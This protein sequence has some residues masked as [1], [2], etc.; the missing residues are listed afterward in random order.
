MILLFKKVGYILF[1]SCLLFFISLNT[2]IY[3]NAKNNATPKAQA[4]TMIILGAKIIDTPAKP[5]KTLTER[6][7]AAIPYLKA[8]LNTKVIVCGG[9]GL[10]ESA[11]EASVM[12]QYLVNHGIEGNRIFEEDQSVRTAQQFILPKK[13]MTLGHTVVVTSD[14]HLLRAMMLAKRSG[15]DVS[16]LPSKTSYQNKNRYLSLIR[17]PLAVL[18]SY[19]FDFPIDN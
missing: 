17:E 7:N 12:K 10:D 2:I 1:F 3:I 16:G 4:D 14:Y 5:D 8:N 15:L 13:M 6:L 9:Q 11:T 18:N 19:F